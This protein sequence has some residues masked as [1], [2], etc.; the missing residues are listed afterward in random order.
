MVTP[1]FL[2]LPGKNHLF[3]IANPAFATVNNFPFQMM[4]HYKMLYLI[5]K[6]VV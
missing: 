1:V 6:N 3:V 4:D 2:G 5:F